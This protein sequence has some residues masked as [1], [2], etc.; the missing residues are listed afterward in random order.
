VIAAINNWWREERKEE[1]R[2]EIHTSTSALRGT[3]EGVKCVGK[4]VCVCGV[5]VCVWCV[6]VSVCVRVCVCVFVYVRER[7]WLLGGERRETRTDKSVYFARVTLL[8]IWGL[9][10]KTQ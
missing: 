10:S 1:S 4:C 8:Y 2:E 3:W 6:C 7:V 5:C 9:I